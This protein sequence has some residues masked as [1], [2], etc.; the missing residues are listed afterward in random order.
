MRT[1]SQ[2]EI[3]ATRT[4]WWLVGLA[5]LLNIAWPIQHSIAARNVLLAVILIAGVILWRRAQAKPVIPAVLTMPAKLF[6]ILSI[7]LLVTVLLAD[8]KLN[9]LS[10]YRGEWLIATL[11]LLAGLLTGRLSTRSESVHA[12]VPLFTA[13]AFALAI[14]SLL[15]LA[16]AAIVLIKTRSLP[17]WDA[18]L[19]GRTAASQITNILY[20]F[21][22]ADA[23]SRSR[24]KI[25]LLP[26]SNLALAMVSLLMLAV[27]YLLNTRNG[28]IGVL[29]LTVF[30]ICIFIWQQ[31]ARYNKAWLMAGG[32]VSMLLLGSFARISYE[33]DNRWTA[34]GESIRIAF[35]T[36][37]NKAW[38]DTGL[39]LPRMSNGHPVDHSAYM[40]LAWAKEGALAIR[41][42][43]LGVGFGRNA[44]GHAMKRKY[45]RGSGHSHSSLIDFTLSGGIPGILLW[46]AFSATLISF[47]WKSYHK[48]GSPMGLA[49]AITI[50]GTLVR[51]IIDSNLR[52][53]GLEQYLFLLAL[54]ATLTANEQK[55]T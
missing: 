13:I 36:E 28:T 39:P 21:L 52:D 7:W 45:G 6:A 54:L 15:I 40:R 16:N 42:N 48:L 53:H 47:G 29:L 4:P 26:L 46:I 43:P 11:A 31:R 19:L 20:G 12:P 37:H 50:A 49:L 27:T 22:V 32:I 18:P 5:T 24:S 35:D 3:D 1:Q 34:F 17:I 44:F 2:P 41:D 14:P 55:P 25:R 9:S 30:A 51:M 23:L 8:D 33:A 38:L 10:Q